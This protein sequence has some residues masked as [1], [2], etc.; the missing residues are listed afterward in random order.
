MKSVWKVLAAKAT[1]T[2][3]QNFGEI[4]MTDLFTAA[5][6]IAQV[7]TVTGTSPTLN[8]YVQGGFI[9]SDGNEN[10][11]DPPNTR[12]VTW[13]DWVSLTQITTSNQKMIAF[14][15]GAGNIVQA[16]KD[17]A[18]AAG[19][20]DN[21]PIPSIIRLKVVIAGTTP[22]FGDFRAIIELIP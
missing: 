8:A 9:D 7:G 2:S 17:A 16:L 10:V 15:V 1:L 19:N 5:R 4:R 14:V 18:L 11:G 6:I 22:S 3:S 12:T 20:A 21:G 13:T